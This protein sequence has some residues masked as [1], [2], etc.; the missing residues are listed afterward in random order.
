MIPFYFFFSLIAI[1]ALS[2]IFPLKRNQRYIILLTLILVLVIFAG[3]RN[4]IGA[5]DFEEYVKAYRDVVKNGFDY[6]KFTTSAAIF[7]PGFILV[8]YLSSFICHSPIWGLTIIALISVG[9]NLTCYHTYLP[10]F[11]LFAV[12]FYYVH[13]YILRDMSLIR[14]GVAA[15]ISLFSLRYVYR[16]EFKKFIITILIAM[17]FHL[18][19]F[20]FI[21]VYPFYKLRWRSKTWLKIVGFSLIF[22]YLFS[23]GRLLESLPKSGILSRISNYSWMIGTSK[24]GVL[25][26]L[27]VLK[28]LFFVCV[29][30][31]FYERISKQVPM[32]KVILIP[33]VL[34]VCWLMIWNDFAIVAARIATFLSVTEVLVIPTTILTVKKASQPVVACCLILLAFLIL[35]MNGNYYLTEVPGLLPYR[36]ILSEI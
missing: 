10:R 34:S 12:L 31:I 32:Y 2:E 33:Y 9:I 5:Q 8:Y 17:S 30:L 36:F 6:S 20:I 21:I 26:N 29:G 16:N 4:Q 15:A 25:S 22:S 13:T 1:A 23:A 18:A 19:S 24:L 27:T 14:S 28:Q 3:C 7:E 11:F 35:Y